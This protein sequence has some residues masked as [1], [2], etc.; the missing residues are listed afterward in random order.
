MDAALAGLAAMQ[1]QH[2]TTL[3]QHTAALAGLATTQAQHT[4]TLAKH[5]AASPA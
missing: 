5:T 1:A 4:T 3:A 2:T